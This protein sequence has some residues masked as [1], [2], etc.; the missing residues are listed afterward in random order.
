MCPTNSINN[1]DFIQNL[2]PQHNTFH[3]EEIDEQAVLEKINSLKNTHRSGFDN[4]SNKSIKHIKH[5]ISEPL[6][7]II[8][9]SLNRG[10]FPDNLKIAKVKPLFKKDDPSSFTNYRPIS[11]LPVI[12]KI[13]EKV[14]HSHFFCYFTKSNMLSH[15]QCDF[16][17]KHSTEHAVP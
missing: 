11:L 13:F 2:P 1:Y 3:F 15:F 16:R 7:M 4:I 10:V 12:S 14:I 17:L 6:T 5:L 9:Q 8:N